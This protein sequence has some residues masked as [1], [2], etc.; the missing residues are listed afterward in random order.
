MVLNRKAY[1]ET[2]KPYWKWEA[3]RRFHRIRGGH[4]AQCALSV[5]GGRNVCSACC[6]QDG[7]HLQKGLNKHN[8]K[9]GELATF[10]FVRLGI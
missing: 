3:L 6:L 7:F 5:W 8:F 2:T 10:L 9:N 1:T 4:G